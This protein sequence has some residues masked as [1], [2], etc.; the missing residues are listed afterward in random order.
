MHLAEFLTASAVGLDIAATS[1]ETVLETLVDLLGI[2]G[3]QRATLLRLLTRREVLGS[4]AV[5]RSL[6]VPH[7][8]TL[9]VQRVRM[10]YVRLATPL[11]WEA[12]DGM[13]VR[14]V[15]MI[16]APPVEVS[17]QYLP[18]L[19]R[20]ARFAKEP[21]VIAELDHLTSAA[22]FRGLLDRHGA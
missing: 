15:F 12:P 16:I 9:V 11:Q 21:G 10:A 7:C 14:H 2:Q 19:G 1:R 6:A 5:G 13:L 3:R 18:A 17:N 4:T 22:D 20:L 8:R